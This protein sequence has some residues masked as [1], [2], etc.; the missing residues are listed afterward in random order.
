MR[1]RIVKFRWIV[2]VAVL[3]VLGAGRSIVAQDGPALVRIGLAQAQA[4]L[5]FDLSAGGYLLDL[6]QGTPAQLAPPGDQLV[7]SALDDGIF[8]NN[9]P[10]GPGPLVIVPDAGLLGWNNRSYRGEFL[11]TASG[12]RLNLINRLPVEDYLRGVVPREVY[13]SW[14]LASLK[15]Q[16]VAART[17]TVASLGRHGAEGFDLCATTHCQ[18]YGG[19]TVEHPNTDR[20]V[21]ETAGQ[22]LT[23]NGKAISAFF[24]DSSGGLTADPAKVWTVSLPYL[25][26][27]YDWDF[28]TPHAQWTR[29]FTWPELQAIAARS[30]PQL[31]TLIQLRPVEFGKDGRVLKLAVKG[32]LGEQTLSGEQFRYQTGIPSTNIKI[33]VVYGPEPA[34]ALW[35][36]HGAVFPEAIV[37]SPEIPGFGAEVLSPPWDL[38]DPWE[39]LRDKEPQLVVVKGSGWG[40]GVGLSQWGAKGMADRGYNERQILEYFYPGATITA[41]GQ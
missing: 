24:H 2:L 40:H 28:N 20:A 37:R 34:I 38:P 26:E 25:K 8:L 9:L 6:G 3:L 23:Y 17:Y 31:G 33:A 27:V 10:I 30:Y 36:V 35:W 5:C 41:L 4:E 21:A 14:P 29:S 13:P 12:G 11:I 22:I 39:W 15:A 18:A 7:V 16:A 1:S 19:A 32:T